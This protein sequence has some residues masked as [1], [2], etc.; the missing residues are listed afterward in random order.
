MT[1]WKSF[2][3]AEKE[4]PYFKTLTEFI[5]ADAKEHT[6]YP[7]HSDVFNAFKL[8]PL[9]KTKL[10]VLGADPYINK[11]QAMG[12]SFSVP[13]GIAIPPSLRNIYKEIQDD[14]IHNIPFPTHGDLTSWA[15]Q[16]ILLLNSVLTVRAGQSGSHANRGW[17]TFTD[18]AISLVGEQGKPTAFLLWGAYAK[19]KASLIDTSKHLV[20]TAAHPSPLSAHNGFFG[21]KHFSR[22]SEWLEDNDRGSIDWRVD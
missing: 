19:K 9:E 20:L 6:I 16:G 5:A 11:G 18:K 17:E 12:L 1:T 22:A 21:C 10:V 15:K 3:N 8:C 4:E 13:R 7:K 2:I 14:V